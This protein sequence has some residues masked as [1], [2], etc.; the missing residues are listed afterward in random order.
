MAF[1]NKRATVAGD[2][3]AEID[4]ELVVVFDLAG[5][6]E[7]F[8]NAVQRV[9]GFE[10][11][12]E[13]LEDS[14][15]PDD[16][17]FLNDR[18]AGPLDSP[19]MHSLQV[20]MS[21]SA[22]ITQLIRLFGMW[23][24]DPE[25]TFDRGLTKFR[26]V[27]EQLR[28][29]RR[30]GPNDRVR[31]TGLLERWR[32]TLE[33]VG[34]YFSPVLV[35]IELWFRQSPN[36]RAAASAYT[37]ALVSAVAGVVKD[38]AQIVEI[39]YHSLLVQLPIQEVETVVNRG[40][41]SIRLLNADQIMFVSPYSPM[42]IR[43]EDAAEI[44]DSDPETQSPCQGL[45]RIALLDGLPHVSH[46][47]LKGR[48]IVDDPDALGENYAT[49]SRH[50][51]T[52][53]ASLIIHGDLSESLEPMKRPLY[54]RPIMRPHEFYPDSE[55]TLDDQLFTDLLHR[56]IR[57]MI[58]GE[59]GRPPS[60]PSVRVVN[61]SIGSETR[62]LVRG[63]S[64]AGRLLDWLAVKYN[65]L[66][67]V[68]AG[69][70]LSVPLK[71]PAEAASDQETAKVEVLKS[72]R[73]SGKLRKILPP[74]DAIN[75]LTVGAI[76]ADSAGQIELPDTV[77]DLVEAGAPSLY[78]A[79]GPGAGRSVKPELHHD[80]GR[81][82]YVR[83]L[84]QT[85]SGPGGFV[86]LTLAS[87]SRTGPGML[88]AAPASDGSIDRLSYSHG[89]S[90]A[91]ALV[92]READRIFD[93][94]ES[95]A[96]DSDGFAFPDPSFH[97]LLAKALLVHSA[98]WGNQGRRLQSLLNLDSSTAR[99]EITALLGYGRL[100]GRR[101]GNAAS[102]RAVL[103]AGSRIG[104]DE[105]HTYNIPLPASLRSK[106]VWHR[107]TVTLASLTPA[108]GHSAKYREA[109]VF[110]PSLDP[111]DTGGGRLEADHNAVRRGACQHEIFD[112]NRAL[113]FVQGDT[114]PLHV[115]CMDHAQRLP[116]RLPAGW[117]HRVATSMGP[118]VSVI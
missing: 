80:G 113:T 100:D 106:A 92:T 74:A 48:L 91:T 2:Q 37:R 42:S 97:P 104:R 55:Q 40:A 88:A 7:K 96:E 46:S 66:F 33:A 102:N 78:G 31:E 25:M 19:V 84:E 81:A 29:I 89:T 63:I 57:R 98:S 85:V 9:E 109:K 99:R 72:A 114:L 86:D 87:T 83:P 75:A 38:E 94:L 32:D 112:G 58:E 52:T 44:R 5:S 15:D 13:Y 53:M 12:A 82:L 1:E 43:S 76:H 56:S 71:V 90:N 45:P 67:I 101:L 105:R 8:R 47:R 16:D 41:D 111:S 59:G 60:A 118:L 115:E 73:T 77:W 4:P 54:V 10:F 117:D 69:N 28:S 36:D 93:L 49:I 103:I 110:F 64:P 116:C 22:A 27:F 34:G 108:V 65:L 6:V 24:A 62:A 3:T 50:H 79:V 11:L 95:G 20:V 39:A 51:G 35:E 18:V 68:S 70:H 61:L 30:W 26:Y 23:Q 107:F 14:D 17:F 21:N